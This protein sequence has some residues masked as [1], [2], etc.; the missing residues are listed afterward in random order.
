MRISDTGLIELEGMRFRAYHGCL[1]AEQEQGGLFTVDFKGEYPLRAAAE[2]DDLSRTLDYGG[3]YEIV[4]Q[5]MA[6]PARL[7]EHVAGRIADRIAA[8][9]PE[10]VRFEVRVSK[11]RPPV[12]GACEWSRVTVRGGAEQR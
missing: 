9:W 10:L 3:V 6:V 8:R 1:P 7:L 2:Q 11:H 12:D 4:A 5:E